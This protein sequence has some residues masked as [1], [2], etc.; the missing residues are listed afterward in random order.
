MR[1]SPALAGPG[2]PDWEAVDAAIGDGAEAAFEFLERLVASPSTVGRELPAQQIVAAELDRLGFEVSEL[3]VPPETAAQAPAGVAQADYAGRPD[4]LGRLNPGGAPSLLLNGHVDVV[5]AESGRWASDPFTPVRAGGWLTGR[6][7]GDMKGG[8]AMGLLAVAALRRAAPGAVS[9][10][11]GFLSVIEEECTGNGTLAACRAGV[12]ADAAVLL[13]PTDLGLLLGGTG[14]VWAEIEIAGVAGHAESADRAV[15]PVRFVPAILHALAGLEDELNQPGDDPAFDG[16]PRPYNVNVGTVAAGDWPSSVPA[17][18]RLGVRVG[19]PRHWTPDDAFDRVRSAV[20]GAAA[21]DPWLASH[22]PSVRP[23]GF[24]AEGY[25]ID[26]G[27]PL[28]TTLA[29]AHASAH[30]GAP[31]QIV[32]GSTTDARYYLNQFGVP[33]VAYGPRSRNIHGTDEAVELASIVSGART[34]ARF[35]AGFFTNG[36]L[37]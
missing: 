26:D 31:R 24:R 37:L 9:G 13:E 11:L 16:L 35:I 14:I 28:V 22:P 19:F 4:V 30:G 17:R 2:F 21:A 7:A 15:N 1:P 5:P 12:L 8:F 18:A 25:L 32:L 10:E 23:A 6:G 27:H 34:M 36:G 20:L 3:S 29:A 33:A